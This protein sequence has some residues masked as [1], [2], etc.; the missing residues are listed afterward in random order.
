MQ[1]VGKWCLQ[2]LDPS[3]SA[4]PQKLPSHLSYV[5]ISVLAEGT[6]SKKDEVLSKS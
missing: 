5:I 6:K 2:V 3:S 1:H 4:F